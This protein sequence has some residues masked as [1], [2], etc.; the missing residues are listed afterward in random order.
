[1][2]VVWW[3]WVIVRITETSIAP[4]MWCQETTA[5]LHGQTAPY[6]LDLQKELP[7]EAGSYLSWNLFF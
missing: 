7:L 2:S 3:K 4:N 6:C 1:M 5:Q